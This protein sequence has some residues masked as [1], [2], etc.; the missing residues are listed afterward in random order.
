MS[1]L[2]LFLWL[3]HA[4]AQLSNGTASDVSSTSTFS[5]NDT[6]TTS[7]QSLQPTDS[8]NSQSVNLCA[9][10]WAGLGSNVDTLV[11]ATRAS[12]TAAQWGGSEFMNPYTSE[13]YEPNTSIQSFCASVFNSSLS[14]WLATVPFT[15]VGIDPPTTWMTTMSST[16]VTTYFAVCVSSM[17]VSI[18]TFLIFHTGSLGVHTIPYLRSSSDWKSLLP[19]Y[20]AD[21]KTLTDEQPSYNDV[22]SDDCFRYSIRRYGLEL[23]VLIFIHSFGTLLRQVQHIR[24]KC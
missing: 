1:S 4:V 23:G 22:P 12:A 8:P 13:G 5:L 6:Q 21:S 20:Y 10:T 3:S 15:A 9:G 18:N 24:W 14:Q 2:A 11:V 19:E 16:T 7:P 17:S